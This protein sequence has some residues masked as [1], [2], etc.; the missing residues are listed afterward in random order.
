MLGSIHRNP[1]YALCSGRYHMSIRL[2]LLLSFSGHLGLLFL[3]LFSWPRH[4]AEVGTHTENVVIQVLEEP[5]VPAPNQRLHPV[6]GTHGAVM[7]ESQ[8]GKSRAV[9]PSSSGSHAFSP[10]PVASR[11]A[12]VVMPSGYALHPPILRLPKAQLQSRSNPLKQ[13]MTLQAVLAPIHSMAQHTRPMSSHRPH[14]SVQPHQMAVDRKAFHRITREPQKDS[15]GHLRIRQV[16]RRHRV[17]PLSSQQKHLQQRLM[18]EEAAQEQHEL[19]RLQLSAL[20]KLVNQY[21]IKI[22]TAIHEQWIIPPM[23]NPSSYCIFLIRLASGGVV[24]NIQLLKSS[25]DQQLD[26]SARVAIAKASPLPVP[27]DPLLFKQF[28][29]LRLIVRPLSVEN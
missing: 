19:R 25:G 8:Q 7:R 27:V 2:P 11:S 12:N 5:P 13:P 10:P 1:D 21:R 28:R 9:H 29:E 3:L 4:P 15:R 6:S 24:V 18:E 20:S 22:L 26:R 14:L 23:A 17:L 16:E